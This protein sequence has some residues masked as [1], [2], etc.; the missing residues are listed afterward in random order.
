MQK[1]ALT[2][3]YHTFHIPT[4]ASSLIPLYI[5]IMQ[6]SPGEREQ[7]L[8]LVDSLSASPMT[9]QMIID[10]PPTPVYLTSKQQ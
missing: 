6:V 5:L 7:K 8:L 3:G 10:R 1:V 4:I 2:D 9:F